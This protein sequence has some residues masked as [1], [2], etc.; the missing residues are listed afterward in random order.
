MRV[1]VCTFASG[2]EPFSQSPEGRWGTAGKS[3][4]TVERR[5]RAAPAPEPKR[6]A[7]RSSGPD[8]SRRPVAY[9]WS[10]CKNKLPGKF[11]SHK[12]AHA[13]IRVIQGEDF[14]NSQTLQCPGMTCKICAAVVRRMWEVCRQRRWT[15]HITQSWAGA[16]DLELNQQVYSSC[17]RTMTAISGNFG[18]AWHVDQCK[19]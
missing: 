11:A 18:K 16:Q 10:L 4:G 13:S 15:Q 14:Q 2:T 6:T 3:V 12:L 19:I 17:L 7:S 9:L 8:H 1:C 5:C